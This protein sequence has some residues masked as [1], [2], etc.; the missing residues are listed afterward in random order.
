MDRITKINSVQGGDFSPTQ[1][2]CDFIIPSGMIIN[3]KKSHLMINCDIQN[4]G[5]AGINNTVITKNDFARGE[6]YSLV[7][8]PIMIKHASLEFENTG[9][10]E[11]IRDVN[12]LRCN[13]DQYEKD[14]IEKVCQSYRGFNGIND[15][16]I[17][18]GSPFRDLV[19]EG[20]NASV[21][22]S[23][24]IRVDMKDLFGL[25][26]VEQLDTGRY[27]QG[28]A[29]FTLDLDD[30]GFQTYAGKTANDALG[31]AYW[32]QVERRSNAS[33]A[34]LSTNGSVGTRGAIGS[35]TIGAADVAGAIYPMTRDYDS[36]ED[37]PF[38]VG[39]QVEYGFTNSAAPPA[40]VA[41]TKTITAIS[42]NSATKK[43]S[44]TVDTVLTAGGAGDLT[45]VSL[46]G[47]DSPAN[48][49]K[50]NNVTLVLYE[51][52]TGSSPP[53]SIQ[54]K[55]Y[56]VEKDTENAITAYSK[57]FYVEPECANMIICCPDG[58]T[59]T[60]GAT[61]ASKYI[62]DLNISDYRLRVNGV[63]L[64][65][66]AIQMNTPEHW[67]RLGRT[68]LN[69]DNELKSIRSKVPKISNHRDAEAGTPEVK[70]IAECF[71]VTASAKQVQVD[72]NSTHGV[73][74]I[75]LFKEVVREI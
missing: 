45:L 35:G 60:G 51:D 38:Y 55:T 28:M 10:V 29:H 58:D 66:R 6:L 75:Y 71:P 22:K 49:L 50:V 72:I 48:S 1:N 64:T 20:D 73:R 8:A 15:G 41:E 52:T 56:T 69:M 25:G 68:F 53:A 27:G 44:L 62:S 21:N 26:E 12:V 57:M 5:T 24:D 61:T 47:V 54:Y 67:D 65:N 31:G 17:L 59:T 42:Y 43:I 3:M 63:D 14:P 18:S 9:K 2:L 37:S 33:A 19:K 30:I 34:A 40:V 7:P 36:L 32:A 74:S 11:D 70:L 16:N 13:L 23:H 39:Q 4:D 46:T